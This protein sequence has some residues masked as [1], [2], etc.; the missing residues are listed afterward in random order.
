MAITAHRPCGWAQTPPPNQELNQLIGAG[1]FEQAYQLAIS[2]LTEWEGDTEFDFIYGIA[3][4]ESGSPNEAVFAFERVALTALDN[5]TNAQVEHLGTT[6]S[7][8][9][10]AN[11]S[12]SGLFTGANAEEF[13]MG[14]DL[15]DQANNQHRVGGQVILDEKTSTVNTTQ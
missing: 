2:N 9:T 15:L 12:L 11:A 6:A 8:F 10:N 3:A 14:F 5:I 1:Q 13:L 4:I 7:T